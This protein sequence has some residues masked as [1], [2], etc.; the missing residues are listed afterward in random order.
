[1]NKIIIILVTVILLQYIQLRKQI[2]ARNKKI[3]L[4]LALISCYFIRKPP[5]I[6][7]LDRDHNWNKCMNEY[8]DRE[9]YR[10]F[11]LTR[12]TFKQLCND[13]Y[14]PEKYNKNRIIFGNK[15]ITK[16]RM[17]A[18]FLYR[19][20]HK[21]T[22]FQISKFFGVS[23]SSV[24]RITK[25]ISDAL[26]TQL[27][28]TEIYF[29]SKST[30]IEQSEEWSRKTGF[31]HPVAAID[32]SHIPIKRPQH[33]WE[34]FFSRKHEYGVQCQAVV[35]SEGLFIDF[36]VGYTAAAHDSR[37]FHNSSFAAKAP[38]L[39][40]PGYY[41]LGDSAYP[42]KP[43]LLTTYKKYKHTPQTDPQKLYNLIHAKTRVVVEHAFGRLKQ[44]W[45]LLKYMDITDLKLVHKLIVA[46]AILHNYCER[47]N[48]CISNRE[49]KKV[50]R[51]L[52]REILQRDL[53]QSEE[54]EQVL[55][56]HAGI[57]SDQRQGTA[58]R[59]Q[60][61]EKIAQEYNPQHHIH[62]Y[63]RSNHE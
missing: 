3:L 32:G 27:G 34:S 15:P 25:T 24:V 6:S 45:R 22:L 1:M 62:Y 49:L 10:T 13:L 44:R 63:D 42:N 58:I 30:L 29:P 61:T 55:D 60:V 41:V 35:D 8:S 2:L 56:S 50:Q 4:L 53:E 26:F 38:S 33:N 40:P 5:T 51:R 31:I 46:A 21:C 37:V 9:F 36:N 17:V 12:Q 16:E 54:S 23:E 59:Q 11:R 19:L 57:S 48:D 20:A 18:V 14:I 7:N 43:W 28:A 52:D 39:I 47:R